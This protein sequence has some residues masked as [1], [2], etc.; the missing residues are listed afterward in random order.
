[1]PS[2]RSSGSGVPFVL[3]HFRSV[4]EVPRYAS[5]TLGSVATCAERSLCDLDPVVQSDDAI[6]DS[7]D[8]VHVVLDDEDRVPAFRPQSRDELGHLVGLDR[9]HPR[10]R[11]VEQQKPRLRCGRTRDLEP[12]AVRVGKAVRGLPPAVADQPVAEEREPLL[13]QLLDLALLAP[14]ARRAQNGTQDARF[15]V[16]VGRGHHV[17]LH[18]HVQEQAQRLERARNPSARDLVGIETEDATDPRT[19]SRL[20]QAGRPR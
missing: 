6:R 7:L 2:S 8:D 15:R 12:A 16:A 10:G 4:A 9:V 5:T 17:L 19:G 3:G 18:R 13:G 1:M 14:H 20:P 11:L